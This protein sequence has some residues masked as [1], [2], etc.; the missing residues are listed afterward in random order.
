ML[1]EVYLHAKQEGVDLQIEPAGAD[2]STGGGA[3]VWD[4]SIGG[5]EGCISEE[6][7]AAVLVLGVIASTAALDK[8]SPTPA[9]VPASS[10]PTQGPVPA[11]SDK[12][13]TLVASSPSHVA[14]PSAADYPGMSSQS[15]QLLQ[16]VSSHSTS[17]GQLLVRVVTYTSTHSYCRHTTAHVKS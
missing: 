14:I 8:I 13:S 9:A 3:S 11:L 6:V 5:G 4:S 17:S 2:S 16:E 1:D 15:I 12:A 10:A 7:V